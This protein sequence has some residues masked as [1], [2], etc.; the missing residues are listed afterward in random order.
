MND[1]RPLAAGFIQTHTGLH[2]SLD[3]PHFRLL[4]IAH[5]LSQTCRYGGHCREFYSV[6]E[7]SIMVADIMELRSLGDPG[8]GLMH[9]ATEAYLSDVPA[10]FKPFL[11]DWQAIDHDLEIA[12][13]AYYGI[14][15][16]TMGCKK[17][18]MLALYIEA[19][20]LMPD[21][22]TCFSDPWGLKSEAATLRFLWSPKRP[23]RERLKEMFLQRARHYG[24]RDS[25][26]DPSGYQGDTRETA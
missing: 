19:Y 25:E 8:E 1:D 24:I 18:D 6:A 15:E 23:D 14:G 5:A 16:K 17:A 12:M 2:F 20:F 21:Q 10:P 4:D 7:H 9:D 3:E 26:A 13:R 11:P 22:G